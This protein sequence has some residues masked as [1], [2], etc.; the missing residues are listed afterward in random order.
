MEQRRTHI[1][2]AAPSFRHPID[3]PPGRGRAHA[4]Q[5][6]RRGTAR[7][8]VSDERQHTVTRL[9][10]EVRDRRPGSFDR[11]FPLVYDE[12][13][14]IARR[15]LRGRPNGTLDTHALVHEA[16]L[17]LVDQSRPDWRTRGHFSA[18]ASTAMRHI[19][20]DWAR[21]RQAAKRGG[22]AGA[23]TLDRLEALMPTGDAP[24]EAR[25]VALNDALSRLEA[26]SPREARIVE[27]RFFGAMTIDEVAEAMDLS[28]ATVK[29][30]W[31][32]ARAW[33]YRE[34]SA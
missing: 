22:G 10:G 27:L 19:L 13:Q 3:A 15:Q 7:H 31:S 11:L 28:P 5:R 1:A 4:R 25:L 18:V 32:L 29:R 6:P 8:P 34:M 2:G 33:L 9:L 12:L 24:A 26:V 23:V 21:R 16:Y 30:G 14:E 17:R 20:I